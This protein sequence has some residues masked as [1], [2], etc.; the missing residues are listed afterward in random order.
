MQTIG[1]PGGQQ[2][3]NWWAEGDRPVHNDSRVTYL[4]DG[5]TTMLMMCRHFITAHDYIYLANWGLTPGMK[6][7]RGTD[8]R[9]G[10]DGS[11]EQDFHLDALADGI[12]K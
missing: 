5:H 1:E 7:V 2:T 9:A 10:P 3:L 6:L 8:H 11:P 4:V 12:T